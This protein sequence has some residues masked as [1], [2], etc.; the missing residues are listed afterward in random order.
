[1]IV[2][3]VIIVFHLVC[4]FAEVKIVIFIAQVMNV[5][6]QFFIKNIIVPFFMKVKVA[7]RHGIKNQLNIIF[8]TEFCDL[9]NMRFPVLSYW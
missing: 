7:A 3:A 6:I 1:M 5:R 9:F 8:F 4:L 2:I